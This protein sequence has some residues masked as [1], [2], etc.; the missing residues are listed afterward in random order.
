[1]LEQQLMTPRQ[2]AAQIL[3]N[4]KI[5]KCTGYLGDESGRMCATGVLIHE[6]YGWD[7][8]DRIAAHKMIDRLVCEGYISSYYGVIRRN[9]KCVGGEMSFTEIADW[10]E[11]TDRT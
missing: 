2:H 8:I 10:L 4:T 9:D 5:E 6:L 3:R 7:G 11:S 1:M